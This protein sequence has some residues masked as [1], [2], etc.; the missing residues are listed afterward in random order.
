MSEMSEV[1]KN[2]ARIN[3]QQTQAKML[4]ELKRLAKAQERTATA[5]EKLA[6]LMDAVDGTGFFTR[7]LR[8]GG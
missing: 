2:L 8:D 5:M 4:G 6:N 1:S 3:A 7:H